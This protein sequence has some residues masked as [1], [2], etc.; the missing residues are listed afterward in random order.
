MASSSIPTLK[1]IFLSFVRQSIDLV[2]ENV[3]IS[4]ETSHINGQFVI[5]VALIDSG[6]ALKT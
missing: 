1:V 4:P 6:V 3:V 5:C 2:E